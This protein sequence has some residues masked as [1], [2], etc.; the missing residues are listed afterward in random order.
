[1]QVFFHFSVFFPTKI[2]LDF[3]SIYSYVLMTI[4][5]KDIAFIVDKSLFCKV[6]Y[7]LSV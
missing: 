4:S 6:Q 3:T 7:K 5:A 1:M 2:K